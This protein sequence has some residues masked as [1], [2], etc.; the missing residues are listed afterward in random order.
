[1]RQ[2]LIENYLK[3]INACNT[4]REGHL[5]DVVLHTQFERSIFTIDK[6]YH[7][8]NLNIDSER[9]IFEKLFHGSFIYSQSLY[10]SIFDD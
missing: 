7:A 4:L 10:Q 1:M 3:R 5:N 2:K 8:K 6:K 9:Q